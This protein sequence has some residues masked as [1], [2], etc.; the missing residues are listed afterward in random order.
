MEPSY[1]LPLGM[2]LI[3]DGFP[4]TCTRTTGI[5]APRVAA[6]LDIHD[7][8]SGTNQITIGD[9]LKLQRGVLVAFMTAGGLIW[10]ASLV[11]T[12]L[13]LIRGGVGSTAERTA[14]RA[15]AMIAA[16]LM[17]A[18]AWSTGQSAAAVQYVAAVATRRGTSLIALQWCAAVL[19]CL[20]A[21]AVA[22]VTGAEAGRRGVETYG[23]GQG[24]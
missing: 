2:C 12:T 13:V 21:W 3:R 6:K 20:F 18:S 17:V 14:A 19:S 16:A 22:K 8:E 9:L 24:G 1:S 11:F 5:S 15:T 10:L 7:T 23:M 4:D